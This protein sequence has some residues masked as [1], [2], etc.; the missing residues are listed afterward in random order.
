MVESTFERRGKS[1]I[2]VSRMEMLEESREREERRDD[3]E[4]ERGVG[5]D[6]VGSEGWWWW[7]WWGEA[8]IMTTSSR[9]TR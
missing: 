2:P 6:T 3:T 1:E 7:W 8:A 5:A 9:M 4:R